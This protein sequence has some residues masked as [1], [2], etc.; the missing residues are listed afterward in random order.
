MTH[1]RNTLKK[2]SNKMDSQRWRAEERLESEILKDCE[3]I[4]RAF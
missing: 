1:A 2:K 4:D 3:K